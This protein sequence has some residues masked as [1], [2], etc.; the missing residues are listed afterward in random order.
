MA[1]VAGVVKNEALCLGIVLGAL[2][3]YKI[4]KVGPSE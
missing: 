4:L 1:C 3:G 2:Q